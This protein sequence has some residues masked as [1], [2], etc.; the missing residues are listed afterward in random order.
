M[1]PGGSRVAARWGQVGSVYVGARASFSPQGAVGVGGRQARVPLS[2]LGPASHKTPFASALGAWVPLRSPR[3]NKG[4][5]RSCPETCVCGPSL[6]S[7]GEAR[8]PGPRAR[9]A[10]VYLA[11]LG[12]SPC[13]GAT[14]VRRQ[15]RFPP[16][17]A[18]CFSFCKVGRERQAP[19]PPQTPPTRQLLRCVSSLNENSGM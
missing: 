18:F 17:Q 5:E 11:V 14:A 7:G 4:W 15:D 16:S 6:L 12:R 8:W 9:G 13:D 10:C 2:A 1:T 19:L 3:L